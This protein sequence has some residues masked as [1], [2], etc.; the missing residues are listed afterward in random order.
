MFAL[1]PLSADDVADILGS[2]L[3]DVPRGL[4]SLQLEV[5]AE[6]LEAMARAADGDARRGLG[7]LETAAKLAGSGGEVDLAGVEEAVQHRF[8]AYDKSGDEHYNL[9]SA[10]HKAIRGGDPDGAL[11]WLARMIEGGED[12]LYIARRLVRMASEDIGLAD[13]AALGVAIAARDAFH[14]LGPPEGEL[15]LAEA[16]VYLASAPKSNR[17]YV[18]WKAA[19]QSARETPA[20]PVPLHIRNAPTELMKELGYG[21]GYRYDPD[22]PGGVASQEYLPDEVAGR[23]FYRPGSVGYEESIRERPERWN[24]RREEARRGL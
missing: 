9:I 16:A 19:L 5:D 20:A 1:R 24:A 11:Y 17:T 18:A 6:A 2:A 4:G 7:I 10:L 13:P 22:E 12:A 3:A 14:F 8:A 21:E 23:T 15:A